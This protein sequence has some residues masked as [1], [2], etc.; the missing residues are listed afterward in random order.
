MIDYLSA[1][2]GGGSA[3]T[4]HPASESG[5]LCSRDR[6]KQALRGLWRTHFTDEQAE[7]LAD[8]YRPPVD[9]SSARV[10]VGVDC[11]YDIDGYDVV[12][13]A[14]VVA[15]AKKCI[16]SR[17]FSLA[18]LP[19]PFQH[20]PAGCMHARKRAKSQAAAAAADTFPVPTLPPLPLYILLCSPSPRRSGRCFQ[21][22]G[23]VDLATFAR[24]LGVR[25]SAAKKRAGNAQGA[26]TRPGGGG[27]LAPPRWC[28]AMVASLWLMLFVGV[29]LS[30]SANAGGDYVLV[31]AAV[32]DAV[33][34]ETPLD[35][36]FVQISS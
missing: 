34:R 10:S 35:G 12:A 15:S 31:A 16:R 36:Q 24:R 17:F 22:N 8:Q 32:V 2:V 23:F 14:V 26:G 1:A 21:M 7:A 11:D 33:R 5:G 6:F 25:V 19:I 30:W 20:R 9:H 3:G 29:S 4:K 28:S 27:V 18:I 13:V